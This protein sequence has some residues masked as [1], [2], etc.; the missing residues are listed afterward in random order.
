MD[1]TIIIIDRCISHLLQSSYTKQDIISSIFDYTMPI[2]DLDI[3]HRNEITQAAHK[4]TGQST[5][6][7]T[8]QYEWWREIKYKHQ[9]GSNFEKMSCVTLKLKE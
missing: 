2:V 9:S 3:K 5:L 4:P 1:N 6:E 7:Q 8:Y